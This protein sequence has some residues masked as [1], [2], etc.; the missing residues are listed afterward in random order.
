MASR[1]YLIFELTCVLD[2]L[3]S[4][5][6]CGQLIA[7]QGAYQI[8]I[9][10]LPPY[11]CRTVSSIQCKPHL[12]PHYDSEIQLQLGS[13]HWYSLF[14]EVR[15]QPW[16]FTLFILT[17]R[18]IGQTFEDIVNLTSTADI[19][20]VRWSVD[21]YV[22]STGASVTD[23]ATWKENGRIILVI[24]YSGSS[25]TPPP[26]WAPSQGTFYNL[27]GWSGA[28]STSHSTELSNRWRW[29]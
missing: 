16:P 9:R 2:A 27:H 29:S 20:I 15:L 10:M 14:S 12:L 7:E 5:R 8:R 6:L 21:V 23:T 28:I 3:L 18:S 11:L 4:W 19:E 25:R 26:V 17:V 24:V 13:A 22:Y 1:D